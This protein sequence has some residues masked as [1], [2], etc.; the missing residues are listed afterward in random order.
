V[1]FF[2]QAG[3][4]L[5]LLTEMTSLNEKVYGVSFIVLCD[6]FWG[7]TVTFIGRQHFL[8]VPFRDAAAASCEEVF[9]IFFF[10]GQ[11]RSFSF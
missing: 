4:S 11:R 1:S 10:E 8:L 6:V 3:H 7:T 2:V 9:C 5:T